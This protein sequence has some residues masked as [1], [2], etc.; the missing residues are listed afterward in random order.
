M[1]LSTLFFG[2]LLLALTLFIAAICVDY[3]KSINSV[4]V[5]VSKPPEV[6]AMD[7][8]SIEVAWYIV[9]AES[10]NGTISLY[11]LGLDSHTMSTPLESRPLLSF[12]TPVNLHRRY[13]FADKI[14]VVDGNYILQI[15]FNS[16]CRFFVNRQDLAIPFTVASLKVAH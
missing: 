12:P 6:V 2:A 9:A 8:E 3:Y 5:R 14:E 4:I 11:L 13:K 1:R 7:T 15:S 16:R 10:C